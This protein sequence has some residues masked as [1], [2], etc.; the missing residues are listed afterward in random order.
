MEKKVLLIVIMVVLLLLLGV[1]TGLFGVHIV[2]NLSML[3]SYCNILLGGMISI[4]GAELLKLLLKR[5]P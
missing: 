3:A 4:V 5:M 2:L 1:S